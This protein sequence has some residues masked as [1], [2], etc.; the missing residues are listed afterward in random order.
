MTYAIREAAAA[1]R[2]APVLTGLAAAMVGMALFVMGL[3]GLVAFNLQT[4]MQVMEERVEVVAY[5]REEVTTAEIELA[6][7]ELRELP[8]VQGVEYVSKAQ[9]LEQA[10]LQFPEFQEAFSD[11]AVNPLPASLDISLPEGSRNR[12]SVLRVVE[13]AGAFPFVEEVDYGGEWVD[14]LF[15]LRRAVA[16]TAVIL[17]AAFGMVAALIIGTALR[18]A[19]FARRDEIYI[20]RLVGAR[21]GFIRRPFLLEGA[22]AGLLGGGVALAL[23]W[24]THRAVSSYFFAV[25]WIPLTWVAGGIALGILFGVLSSSLAVRKHLRE[26]V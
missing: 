4:T 2:R 3:F 10:R 16:I 25:E 15:S 13:V 1:F 26:V 19:I 17:G 8:E 6:V 5:L 18:I 23:T 20:M 9:A 21:D 14:R 7:A 12:E 24:V 22:M 11:L